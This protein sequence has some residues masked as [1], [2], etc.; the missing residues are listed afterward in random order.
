MMEKAKQLFK[1]NLVLSIGMIIFITCEF[2]VVNFTDGGSAGL[3]G[4]IWFSNMVLLVALAFGCRGYINGR[5]V[6][7]QVAIAGLVMALGALVDFKMMWF[8]HAWLYGEM[9]YI[10]SGVLMLV[11]AVMMFMNW[12][13]MKKPA[14]ENGN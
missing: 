1:T 10:L 12:S 6:N 13:K 5:H 3:N 7:K 11:A 2:C 8:S 14:V 9:T 4:S